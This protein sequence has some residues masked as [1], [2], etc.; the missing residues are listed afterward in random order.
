MLILFFLHIWILWFSGDSGYTVTETPGHWD[1]MK[2]L[3]SETSVL[4]VAILVVSAAVDEFELGMSKEGHTREHASL[5][6]A[7]GIKETVVAINKMDAVDYSE[8]RY[9]EIK[10]KISEYLSKVGYKS[11]SINYVP[12][13]GFEGDNLLEESE[14]TSWYKGSTL[15]QALDQLKQPI[16]LEKLPL[17]FPIKDVYKVGGIGTVPMGRVETGVFTAGSSII[18]APSGVS[19]LCNSLEL[20]NSDSEAFPGFNIGFHIKE[21]KVKDI[22][23]GDVVGD[24]T[25]DPP[26]DTESFVA[27][28]MMLNLS[29]KINVGDNLIVRVHTAH[30][31]CKV[32]EII[33]K[34]D[35]RSLRILDDPLVSLKAKDIWK[36]KFVPTEPLCIE[37]YANYPPLGRFLLRKDKQFVAIG[38]VQDVTKKKCTISEASKQKWNK[39]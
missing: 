37:R 39:Y 25:N 32:E 15:I 2:N 10:T 33:T 27:Y 7:L 5:A 12:I 4:G 24:I 18:F 30:V 19:G 22:K 14:N 38:I 8:E 23:R 21:L 34:F 29:G 35:K 16:G 28:V 6:F 3:I 36:I 13:S 17:R 9:E 31:E 26:M 11:D 20:N 1:F